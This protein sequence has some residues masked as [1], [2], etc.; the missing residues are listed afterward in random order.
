[1]AHA[2][3]EHER[4]RAEQQ[5]N[6]LV[7]MLAAAA[8]IHAACG[9][10]SGDPVGA[11]QRA[12]HDHMRMTSRFRRQQRPAQGRF[13][14]R[15]HCD[16]L[17]SVGIHGGH[18]DGAAPGQRGHAGVVQEP[19]QYQNGLFV[20]SSRTPSLTGTAPETLGAQQRG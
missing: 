10:R 4:I 11:H 3:A 17:V 9:A 20:G 1:M 15:K 13:T 6:E 2:D 8:H 19:A 18:G 5:A 7:A 16:A 14:C 12:I